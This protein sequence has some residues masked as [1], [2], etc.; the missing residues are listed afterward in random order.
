MEP[1]DPRRSYRGS[2]PLVPK[3][4][5]TV[6]KFTQKRFTVVRKPQVSQ[7]ELDRRWELTF[8]KKPIEKEKLDCRKCNLNKDCPGFG[9][10]PYMVGT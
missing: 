8:G 4:G 6:T 10:C 3:E 1:D 7:E 5:N 2:N 9:S